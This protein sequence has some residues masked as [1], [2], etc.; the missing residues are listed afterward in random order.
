[1]DE[2]VA[3]PR[4]LKYTESKKKPWLDADKFINLGIVLFV[5]LN[6]RPRAYFNNSDECLATTW[7]SKRNVNS[8][9]TFILDTTLAEIKVADSNKK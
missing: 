4:N 7:E 6:K 2:S 3:E 5:P 1:M 9:V 8:T